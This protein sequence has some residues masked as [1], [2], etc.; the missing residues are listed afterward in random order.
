MDGPSGYA[1]DNNSRSI[2]LAALRQ[3]ITTLERTEK[4]HV[5]VE[6]DTTWLLG[7]KALDNALPPNGL[8]RYA[9][10]EA[11]GVT[12]ADGPSAAA[13]LAA[14]LHR[15]PY[16]TGRDTVLVCETG[17]SR[18]GRLHGWGWRDLGGDPATLLIVRAR[19]DKEILWAME[20]GLRSGALAAVFAEIR[21]AGF[22]MTRRLSLAAQEGMTP[23]LLLRTTNSYRP[24][25]RQR[26]G[27]SRL[28]LPLATLSTPML[29][30]R[31]DGT[32]DSSAVAVGGPPAARSSGTLRRV[33]SYGCR[34]GQSIDDVSVGWQITSHPAVLRTG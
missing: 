13:F 18:F 30:E 29:P 22:T 11:S 2:E 24:A 4:N 17:T 21:S 3:R 19:N 23:A 9:L 31:S 32:S 26:D 25:R 16:R 15:L 5:P 8:A 20:E 10:H 12:S 1:V 33:L 28:S 27:R 14:L 34:A 7:I 6:L